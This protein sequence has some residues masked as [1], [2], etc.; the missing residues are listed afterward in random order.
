MINKSK[1][2]QSAL[3]MIYAVEENGGS[4][5]NFDTELFWRISLEKETDHYRNAQA[6]ALVHA[7]RASADCSR[8]LETRI[9]AALDAL[10]GDLTAAK[11]AEDI[12]RLQKRSAE[13]EAAL[14]AMR[15][16]LKDKRRDTTDQ[17][18]K[19]C[20]TLM[21]LAVVV[22]GLGRALLPTFEDY[23][24]YRAKLDSLKSAIMRRG[25]QMALSAA[26]R[27][28]MALADQ[29]EYVGLVR[30][31]QLLEELRP[32]AEKLAL[33]VISHREQ[34]EERLTKLLVNYS[35]ARLDVVD[36]CI[37]YLAF[38][39]MDVNHLDTPIVVSEAT[40]LADAYSGGKSAPFIHGIISA[41]AK[42]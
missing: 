19:C 34:Y 5:Q 35:T 11:L 39:E 8:L 36:K 27:T 24:Q 20:R 4:L 32:V 30:D 31:A 15:Y 37:I 41:A 10:H 6:K 17:L 14:A 1:V 29:N 26:M 18:E 25:K 21:D 23:P 16:S 2:R 22:E 13:Y 42:A 3:N 33:G 38:Y 7:N 9:T 28:P 40:A 12:E